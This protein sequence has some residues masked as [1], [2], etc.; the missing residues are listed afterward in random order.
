MPFGS[1]IALTPGL[2]LYE[3]W[4]IE[5][6]GVPI[7][8]LRVRA[9]TILP[10]LDRTGQPRHIVDAGSGRG[11]MTMACARRFPQADVIGV[12][13]LADQNAVNNEIAKQLGLKNVCFKT[14]DVLRL[15]ELGT[16]DVI[17]SSDTLEHLQDDVGGVKM[18]CQALN[19]GGYLIVH[20][21]HLTRSLFG[22]HKENWMDIEGHVRPGYTRDGLIR[23]LSDVGLRVVTC[24]YNYNSF[25]TLANDISKLITGA[26]EQN[27]GLYAFAFPILLC[28]AGIGAFFRPKDDGS[29][30]VALAV[31]EA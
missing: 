7:L 21:P 1:E 30:L 10:L 6:F 3:R 16:F 28:M 18:F 29:G 4:Y 20:V 17:I 24:L 5:L 2:S 19:P 23:L 26:K 15:P 8:G 14:W 13:L 25:E 11:V 22:W 27:K 12:D 9:R 31:R